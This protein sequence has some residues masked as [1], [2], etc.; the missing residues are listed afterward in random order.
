MS[1]H[2]LEIKLDKY[3]SQFADFAKQL[4]KTPRE[5]LQRQFRIDIPEEVSVKVLEDSPRKIHLVLP[6]PEHQQWSRSL[7][8]GK[9]VARPKRKKQVKAK[10]VNEALSNPEFRQALMEAPKKAVSDFLGEKIPKAVKVVVL[11]ETPSQ[12][13]LVLDHF[14]RRRLSE[15]KPKD[16]A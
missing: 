1:R 7:K 8:A 11:E 13:Y 5:L 16:K 10:I 12:I 15:V 6:H 14:S 3:A 4:K 9:A 2:Q